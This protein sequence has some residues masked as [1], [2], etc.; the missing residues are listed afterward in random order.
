MDY[1]ANSAV[2]VCKHPQSMPRGSC[3]SDRMHR[4]HKAK[5]H[6]GSGEASVVDSEVKQ[7]YLSPSGTS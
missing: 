5:N 6:S 2:L 3:G 1:K 7:H 4:V